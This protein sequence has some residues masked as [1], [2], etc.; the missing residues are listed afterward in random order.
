MKRSK[1]VTQED[2]AKR[3]GVSTAVVSQVLS[4]RPATSIRVGKETEQ[5]VWEAVRAMGYVPNLMA[6]SLAQGERRLLGVFTY[7]PVFDASQRG[8]YVPFLLGIEREA[9]VQGYDLLL[10]TS[11]SSDKRRRE[12]Y[13]GGANRLSLAD[14]AILLG[15]SPNR[16]D[17]TRLL[18]EQFPFV[19]IGRRE[20]LDEAIPYVAADYA[21]A[22][23][24]LLHHLSRLGH[25][26]F[27]LVCSGD[28]S[29]S[30]LDRRRGYV[31]GCLELGVAD[32]DIDS[33]IDTAGGLTTRWLTEQRDAGVTAVLAENDRIGRLVLSLAA[34]AEL[35]V[36]A[37]LSLAILGDPLE[38]HDDSPDWL[39]FRIPRREM[40]R[41]AVRLLLERITGA[42]AEALQ[43][44]LPC[45]L[46]EGST[47]RARS[48]VDP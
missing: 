30:D 10:F 25:R 15:K 43:R 21:N 26:R 19:S 48:E 44:T 38:P 46:V 3:A 31:Q 47:A 42:P 36:P 23:A 28:E 1:R 13:R 4:R 20:S 14:G 45:D 8:F 18:R 41:V 40:G 39:M 32:S 2:V 27:A 7:E 9:E 22:T 24:A 11:A 17:L 29:E 34:D 35:R 5:R 6:Q 37:D 16:S 33:S 12:V